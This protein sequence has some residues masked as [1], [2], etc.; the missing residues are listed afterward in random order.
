MVSPK[1]TT[2]EFEEEEDVLV[3]NLILLVALVIID[4]SDPHVFCLFGNSHSPSVQRSIG[5]SGR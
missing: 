2:H 1:K 3:I 4:E 5:C